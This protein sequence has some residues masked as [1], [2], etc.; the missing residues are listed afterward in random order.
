MVKHRFSIPVVDQTGKVIG[1]KCKG[2]GKIV[3][4]ENHFQIPPD[5]LAEECIP[6]D[7]SQ[8]VARTVREATKE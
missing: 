5:A 3:E 7:S 1:V 4:F 2:C 6:K 8:A